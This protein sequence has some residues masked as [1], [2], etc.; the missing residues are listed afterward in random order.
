MF[1]I[2]QVRKIIPHLIYLGTIVL[3]KKMLGCRLIASVS[4]VKSNQNI[5]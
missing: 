2:S 5:A 3:L 4:V 1:D